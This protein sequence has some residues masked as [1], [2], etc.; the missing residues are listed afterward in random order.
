[1]APSHQCS[2]LILVS[3]EEQALRDAAATLPEE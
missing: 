2:I 3:L 1:M